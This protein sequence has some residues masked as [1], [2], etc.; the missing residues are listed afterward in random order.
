LCYRHRENFINERSGFLE[1]EWRWFEAHA[2]CT[3]Y[4]IFDWLSTWQ[5]C[6][7]TPA[8]V[9][10]AIVTGRCEDGELLLILPLA[11]EKTR[12]YRRLVFLGRD[13]CD[14]NAPLLA[15][16]F[17]EYVTPSKFI[18]LWCEVQTLDIIGFKHC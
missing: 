1:N 14:Y 12:L 6:V 10:P 9:K 8:G 4:Q 17:T 5:H 11:I 7:G 15:P 18:T 3:P 2:D 13:L 16:E